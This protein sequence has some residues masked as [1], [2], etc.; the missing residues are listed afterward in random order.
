[1]FADVRGLKPM[2]TDDLLQL[3][4]AAVDGELTPLE[5]RRLGRL[6]NASP[7]ARAIHS[8]LL[9]DSNKLHALPRLAPPVDLQSR[10]MARI[11]SMTPVPSRL[12]KVT[13][14]PRTQPLAEPA[15]STVAFGKKSRSWVP[16]AVAASLLIGV[17]ASSFLF[18]NQQ[19]PRSSFARNPNRPPPSTHKGAGDPDWAKWLP[20][21]TGPRPSVP[22]PREHPALPDA[23]YARLDFPL[24]HTPQDTVAIAPVPR[25]VRPDLVGARPLPETRFEMVELKIPFL[26]PLAAFEAEDTRQLFVDELARDPAFRIDL[27]T[28][29]P[30]RA[31]ELFREASKATGVNLLA[32][33]NTMTQ[34]QKRTVN[35]TVI[36]TESLTPQELAAL[37]AKL[38]TED[39]KVSPHVYDML[40]ATAVSE[41]DARDLKSVL[42][43]DPGLFKRPAMEKS[44]EKI[45]RIPD[46]SKPLSSG[47]AD[48]IVKSVLTGH[49]KP[50]EKTAV[51]LTWN[52]VPG[53]PLPQINSPELKQFVAKRGERKANAVPVIIVIRPGNG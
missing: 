46:P 37:M 45:D 39:A 33:A 21:D 27:F 29:N 19:Q 53:R 14:P 32:D 7:E 30:Q 49:T 23:T 41:H 52:V 24:P 11:A 15:R 9:A 20:V 36:Y 34:L 5:S 42:G 18:F 40:H 47:T 2:I 28:R 43:F 44:N 26:K 1:M 10:V 50:G 38:N 35:A 4:T 6:L 16:V 25:V 31:V 17:T 13:P 51:L 12:A 48:Q 3:I 22:V 8:K